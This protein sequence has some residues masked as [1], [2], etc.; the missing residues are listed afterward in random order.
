MKNIS[1]SLIFRFLG[2]VGLSIALAIACRPESSTSTEDDIRRK[3]LEAVTTKQIIPI[4][5]EHITQVTT[6]KE[7][8]DVFCNEPTQA[9]LTA[10]RNAW[11]IARGTWK[12]SEPFSFGPYREYPGRFGPKID[13]WPVRPGD[14]E[15][16]IGEETWLETGDL[17]QSRGTSRGYASIEYLLY[18]PAVEGED[19]TLTHFSDNPKNCD[20][21]QAA[22]QDLLANSSGLHAAWVDPENGYQSDLID[23]GL[24]S[25]AFRSLNKGF[26]EVINRLGFTVEN[27]REIKLA[28]AAGITT[29]IA[30]MTL[31]ESY[32]SP[33]TIQDMLDN[34]SGVEA[35]YLGNYIGGEGLGV[36]DLIEDETNATNTAML[37]GL[38]TV[39]QTLE[40]LESPMRTAITTET[41]KLQTL[42]E[43]LTAL[44]RVIQIDLTQNL[45][46]TLTFNETDGD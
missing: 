7:S 35:V 40:S 25:T 44:Q 46:V 10:S 31:L 30:D 27:I 23:S 21:L 17:S 45:G 36:D 15:L 22:S 26:S 12:K 6:L 24:G 41:E 39:K 42:Y 2:I 43:Q 20:F 28:K 8:V 14:I 19:E 4:Y 1:L 18:G 32:Y 38:Q 33:R 16:T 29:T 9:H 11:Q 34:L 13:F 5:A 3:F 37:A